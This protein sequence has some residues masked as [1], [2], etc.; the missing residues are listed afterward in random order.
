MGW[1]RAWGI[2]M[3]VMP[4]GVVHFQA[5]TV[6]RLVSLAA[7]VLESRSGWWSYLCFWVAVRFSQSFP[8][9][10]G[11]ESAGAE[12]ATL[13]GSSGAGGILFRR[14]CFLS[15]GEWRNE[16]NEGQDG[17]SSA[18]GSGAI[19]SRRREESVGRRGGIWEG[20]WEG[21][22]R[23]LV[24]MWVGERVAGNARPGGGMVSAAGDLYLWAQKGGQMLRRIWGRHLAV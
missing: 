4:V 21:L 10:A 16:V 5:L 15:C 12:R 7:L 11:D 24:M 1:E 18:T 14:T 8:R 13:G 2:V 22:G 9:P 20:V 3:V 23:L 17:G 19:P 6:C